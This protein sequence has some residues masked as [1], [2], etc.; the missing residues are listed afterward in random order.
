MAARQSPGQL[1]VLEGFP[2][3]C[4]VQRSLGFCFEGT[5]I[6]EIERMCGRKGVVEGL[7]GWQG[8]I[9][10]TRLDMNITSNQ[11]SQNNKGEQ[12]AT[13]TRPYVI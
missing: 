11:Q 4:G 1:L 7:V 13:R 12:Q 3:F 9:V 10:L 5:N 2:F 6:E 8:R